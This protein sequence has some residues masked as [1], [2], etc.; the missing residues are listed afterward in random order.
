MVKK[1]YKQTK[2]GVIPEDWEVN[3]IQSVVTSY[4]TGGNYKNSPEV[5]ESP[6]I[7]MGNLS[8]GYFSFHKIEYVT[9]DVIPNPVDRLQYGDVLFNTRNTPELVGKTAVWRNEL[10]CAYY[11]LNLLRFEFD[12]N[13]ME[14]FFFNSILNTKEAIAELKNITK[15]T[16]SVAAIYPQ[17]LMNVKIPIPPISEQRRIAKAITEM[18]DLIGLLEKQCAK[19]KSIKQGAMQELL[20]GKRRLP[21]FAGE[22]KICR[23]DE[24]ADF[25]TAT[26][27]TDQF[28]N[29][30]YVG[31][32]NMI[33]YKGDVKYN[34]LS[35]IYPK[36]RQYQTEDIILSNIRPYLQ[37]IWYATRNGGCSNDVLVIRKKDGH[38]VEPKFLY[39]QL[40]RDG[41]Y[42]EIMANAVGT[43]M[44][45]GDKAIVKSYRINMPSDTAEQKAIASILSDADAEIKAME[46]KLEKYRQVKQGM[47]QQLLT[48]KIRLKNDIVDS[49]HTE[50]KAT[51]KKSPVRSAH[52][53]QFDDAVAIAAIV[54][55][56][57]SDK[58]PL[59][60]VKVQKLLY[61]LHRHQAVSV[62]DFKKK[63]AGPYADTVRYKGGEPIA[64]KNKYIVSENGK[65]GTRYS[66][67]ENMAQALNYVERWGMQSDLQWLKDNFLHTGRNDLELFATVDMAICDLNEAGVPISV[68]S[69]KDLIA[70]SKEWKAKLSKTYFSDR[71]IARAIKKCTEL[72]N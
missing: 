39:Y 36:V 69:I 9:R 18:D 58:Y 47:M 53:H 3:S 70:S 46:E 45:R 4:R 17:D 68:A 37:K 12:P 55:A 57:Y 38:A 72:F 66:R 27:S 64:K 8:R 19:K 28:D 67:G 59:G 51:A 48:G 60:R 6:V 40:S 34:E 33:A 15:G 62:S 49:V 61:L 41:F 54:D 1:G 71:D 5:T 16:T 29:R 2:I 43:K 65:Q 13:R 26:I 44:P 11:N 21:G 35:L 14:P 23:L 56:F 7:K 20:T 31:T 32:D 24:I 42:D 25:P 50:Q 52:N 63:A 22:W 10:S 30:F